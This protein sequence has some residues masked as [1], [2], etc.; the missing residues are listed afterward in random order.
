M[1]QL[2][3]DLSYVSCSSLWLLILLSPLARHRIM[4]PREQSSL[5]TLEVAK[6]VVVAVL[7]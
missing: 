2:R 4:S 1:L 7:L 6:V 5:S 3:L